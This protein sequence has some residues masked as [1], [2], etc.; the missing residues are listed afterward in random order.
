MWIGID[1]TDSP[2]G[3]CTT[4]LAAVLV[5]RLEEHG[6]VVRSLRLVRLNPNVIW[7]T[8]GNAAVAIEADGDPDTAF[9]LAEAVIEESADLACDDTHPGLVVCS[10]TRPPHSFAEQAIT[11]FCTLDE[12][13]LACEAA[14]ARYYGWKNRRGLIG[15]TAAVAAVFTD[16]TSEILVYRDPADTQRERFVDPE[17]LDIADEMTA[18]HTWDTV[19]RR[20]RV[21]V[22]VPHTPDPV[23]FGIRGEN[24]VWVSLARHLVV[25]PPAVLEAVFET[26]QGTDAHL[27]SGLIGSLEE[28][29]SYRLEGTVAAVPTTG[30]GGHVSCRLQDQDLVLPCM[31]Y[32]PTKEFRDLI[33]SLLPGD[34]VIVCGSWKQGSL[35]LEKIRVLSAPPRI[36]RKAP[37]CPSCGKKMTSAGFGKGF[38]CRSC[39]MR[40]AEP[41]IVTIE[42]TIQPGWYEVPP[43]ARRHLSRPLIRGTDPG[44]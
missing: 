44:P 37:A 11:D 21:V 6:F 27:V 39:S 9:L 22:C 33:R 34:R 26:N 32:E 30:E 25:S 40:S 43:S 12:A 19:D 5:R 29:R 24:P 10:G 42:R 3:M 17:S 8:R 18:P 16:A 15:A 1:D 38:K 14:G 23:L 31:A 36:I 41:E 4:Y 7:K 28:G 13:V 20:N 35:N 2:R